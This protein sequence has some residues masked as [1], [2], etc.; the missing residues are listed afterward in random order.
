MYQ[1]CS[2]GTAEL[3]SS[4]VD[5]LSSYIGVR[6]FHSKPSSYRINHWYRAILA[7][8]TEARNSAS[9]ELIEIAVMDYVLEQYTISTYLSTIMW[10]FLFTSAP[11]KTQVVLFATSVLLARK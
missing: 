11:T 4:M 9:V 2:V 10:M 1:S 7:Q 8:Q 6:P 5:A 3:T